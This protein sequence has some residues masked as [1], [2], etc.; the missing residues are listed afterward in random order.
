[1]ALCWI[2]ETVFIVFFYHDLEAPETDQ[3]SIS[4]SNLPSDVAESL[5]SNS[6]SNQQ[7]SIPQK[8]LFLSY[9]YSGKIKNYLNIAVRRIS[10]RCDVG[11]LC[12]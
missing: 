11:T 12:W 4:E 1:M 3:I 7:D 8:S 10:L 9:V 2:L 6:Q 5:T